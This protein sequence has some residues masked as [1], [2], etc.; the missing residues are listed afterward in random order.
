[1]GGGGK[2][3]KT[4]IVI[5][6]LDNEC[7]RVMSLNANEK[8]LAIYGNANANHPVNDVNVLRSCA[9]PNC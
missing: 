8:I 2:E 9:V 3:I 5:C 1:M 4:H 6:K 7:L